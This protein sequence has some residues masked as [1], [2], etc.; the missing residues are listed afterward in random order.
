M[1]KHNYYQYVPFMLCYTC[2]FLM[3]VSKLQLNMDLQLAVQLAFVCKPYCV[4][5]SIK[6]SPSGS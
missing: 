4:T 6:N 3:Q 5:C 1:K 2:E